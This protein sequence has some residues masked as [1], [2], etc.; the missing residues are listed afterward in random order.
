MIAGGF[1]VSEAKLYDNHCNEFIPR[2]VND[3]YVWFA[4]GAES[5]YADIASVNANAV[6]IV[7]ATGSQWTRVSGSELS[8]VLNWT[9]AN[10]LVAILEVHDST[11]W[12]DSSPAVHPDDAVA[13]WTSSDILDAIRG[14]EAY[15]IINIANEAF[16]NDSTEQWEPFY[17]GAVA[18]LRDAGIHH[19]LMIDAPNWGQDWSN[20]M[21]DGN[22]PVAIFDA[23]P[24]N[25]VVF[26]IHMYDVYGDADTVWT[27]FTNS[28]EKGV[29]LVV[30]EFAADHGPDAPVDEGAIMDYATQL[31]IG[32]LGWSWSGN[33]EDLSS[34]DVT[35]QF[36]V[37]NLTPWG[38][39]LVNGA[40][41]LRDTAKPCT[42]FAALRV[43]G[44]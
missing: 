19:T 11:G 13:Y 10:Q 22:G 2:G 15:A 5:R 16:G 17:R 27:Y 9:K 28:L 23:D 42:C 20:T 31:G 24:D 29:P 36:D 14:N 21:R 39:V 12:P 35:A 6:R 30:G 7:L 43:A 33:N 34:L 44:L 26:S 4:S 18:T 25:N 3:P 37:N 32:Y 41:G 38:E 40:N 8:N 1:Y